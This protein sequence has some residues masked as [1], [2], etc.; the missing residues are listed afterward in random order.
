VAGHFLAGARLHVFATST[1][2]WIGVNA[3]QSFGG[4]NGTPVEVS[5]AGWSVKNRL[6][7]AGSATTTWLGRVRQLDLV[8]A[9]RWTGLKLEV[10]AR[11]GARPWAQD[12]ERASGGLTEA[13][14]E[15]T[16][17]VPLSRWLSLSLGGGKYPSDP[18]RRILGAAYLSAGFRLGALGKP[19]LSV[20]LHTTGVLRGRLVPTEESGP[21]LEVTGSAERRTLRVR[22]PNATLVALMGDFTDWLPVR[23]TQVAPAVW[24][25][26]LVVPAGVHRVN[27]RV[28]GGPW[29]APGGVRAH[30]PPHRP[31]AAPGAWPPPR[32]GR[33]CRRAPPPRR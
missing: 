24:E 28:D 1:G 5:V 30:R 31:P 26:E 6:A 25:I 27:I 21:P 3:G 18:V 29:S 8:G 12:P 10:E 9:A 16:A 7:L 4:P 19:A 15:I 22:A 32:G 2:G 17:I 13:Y 33:R 20:P 14:G 11:A 23:L